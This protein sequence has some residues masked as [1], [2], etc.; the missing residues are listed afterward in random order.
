[1]TQVL[2]IFFLSFAIQLNYESC[3]TE[4]QTTVNNCQATKFALKV[5]AYN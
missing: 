2:L 3:G 1:M 5:P 4:C